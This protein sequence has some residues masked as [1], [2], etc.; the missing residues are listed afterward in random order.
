MNFKELSMAVFR[1]FILALVVLLR[2]SVAQDNGD[3]VVSYEDSSNE[4]HMDY[5]NMLYEKQYLESMVSGLNASIAL[6]NNIGVVA[7][8]C[9]DVNAFWAPDLQ[10]I[11]I[12]YEL[13]EY[14]GEV[15]RSSASSEEELNNEILGAVEFIFY[16][17][18]G[19]ALIDT[20][21]IPFT[22]REE[23]AVDQFSSIILMS[24]GKAS[25]ALSGAS[26]F[27]AS[28][29]A[30]LQSG[31][32]LS[33]LAFWDEH[34]LDQQRFYD[35]VCLV[36]G[37][38][39]ETYDWLLKR[40]SKGF[41]LS[42]AEGYLPKERAERCTE[43]Y[44][45]ISTSWG[46]LI[47]SYVP[48]VGGGTTPSI[49]A[50]PEPSIDV[51]DVVSTSSYNE[52]FTGTLASG[53]ETLDNG[54]YFD[55]FEVELIKGQEV[56][57]ELSS[58]DFDTHLTVL[59]PD[60]YGYSNEDATVKVDGY[61]SRLTLPITTTG[62]WLIGVSS[63]AA[64]ETGNYEVGVIKTDG[65]YNEV[66]SDTLADGDSTYETGELVDSFEYTFEAGQKATV[67]LSSSEFDSYLVVTSPSGENFVNDDYES[68]FG[69]ARV[70]F[71]VTESGTYT[72]SATTYEVGEK[73]A[74]Q[75]AI[76][77]RNTLAPSAGLFKDEQ[78]GT[79]ANSDYTFDSGEFYD[80]I[81]YDFSLGQSLIVDALS[82]EF[83]TY[84][85]A[86]SPS[87][88]Q[89]ENDNYYT[90]DPTKTNA[91]LDI[92]VEEEGTWTFLI[93][94]SKVGETGN[95]T[96][97]ISEVDPNLTGTGDATNTSVSTTNLFKDEKQGTLATS[98]ATFDSGEYYDAYEYE[99]TLGQNLIFDVVS[100]EFD[101]YIMAVSPSNQ[102]YYNDNYNTDDPAK[103]DAG[104]DIYIEEAGTWNVY[105]SSSKVGEVGNY[106]LLISDIG[107][108]DSADTGATGDISIDITDMTSTKARSTNMG[109]LAY[110]DNTLQ[111]GSYVDYYSVELE[112]G[113]EAT[114]SVLSADFETYLG[115]MKPNG[116]MLEFEGEDKARS[117]ITLTVEESGT[118]FVFVT[119]TTAGQ[120]GN[121]LLSIKK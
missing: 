99:F 37:S 58:K 49:E 62:T 56:T 98:D 102:Q 51:A 66:F 5:A 6:P 35:I 73:G 45:D 30:T 59:A 107:L 36:Y 34:S 27:F 23:D 112:A 103:T 1:T 13:F 65:V 3:F 120:E 93:S 11:I 10:T 113:Q 18:L 21:S 119:S 71:D 15:F 64:G 92:D 14:L 96:F 116:E 42:S 91:G 55:I 9:D 28:G 61:L 78:Q 2:V 29:E 47:S 19:H 105:V 74:Y 43:E 46:T 4:V 50:E 39:P 86:I 41:L 16:H 121:Y 12:C 108:Q 82:D 88:K 117:K 57:F 79:L 90:D 97:V 52:T 60:D 32:G 80:V 53:D 100:S 25:S 89:L 75:V 114:F 54:E 95:Y 85:V 84:I 77:T 72:I 109:Q 115:V 76:S 68:Q 24:A 40:E 104:L 31:A 26:F 44:K 83:D 8:Q 94:S 70:D 87:E 22:G 111:D 81:K 110:G 118:F 20:F 101:T 7:G 48:S 17:E 67:V 38:D 63:Y 106:R 69:L 33:D